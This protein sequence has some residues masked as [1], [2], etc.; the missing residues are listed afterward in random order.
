MEKLLALLNAIILMSPALQEH[1]RTIIRSRIIKKGT[2]IQKAGSICTH[3]WFIE[4]GLIRI[5][6]EAANK[7]VVTWLL[8][9]GDIF[10]AVDSFFSQK[11]SSEYIQALEDMLIWGIS[12]EELVATCLKYIE[13]NNHKDLIKTKYYELSDKIH[14]MV[15]LPEKDR[16]LALMQ[17]QP[18]L[19]NRVKLDDLASYLQM[20]PKTLSKI[21]NG[22]A[23][24]K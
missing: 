10:I 5:Y 24:G 4:K 19:I 22:L 14:K 7:E 17:T 16:Y 12:Y 3:I 6:H 8:K 21:R 23:N 9:E 11:P 13:F 20:A 1:L 2:Y 18:D 15:T